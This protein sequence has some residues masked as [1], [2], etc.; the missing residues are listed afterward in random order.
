VSAIRPPTVAVG[1]SRIRISLNANLSIAQM[2]LFL[3]AL[4][5]ARESEVVPG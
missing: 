3:N 5:A 2:D 4:V 1:T